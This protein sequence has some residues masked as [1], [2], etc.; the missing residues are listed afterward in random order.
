MSCSKIFSEGLPELTYEVIRH[1][2]NDIS[3]LHS[4]IL[5]NR[6]WCR[7]AIPLLW[8]NPFSI[9][10][11]NFNFIEIYLS[12][13]NNN[14]KTKLNDYKINDYSLPSNTLFNYPKFL[15]HLNIYNLISSV[16]RWIKRTKPSR[17]TRNFFQDLVYSELKYNF[18][19]L[20]SMSLFKIIIE[21]EPN[22]HTLEIEFNHTYNKFYDEILKLILQNQNFIH[23]I[24]HLNLHI[25]DDDCTDS[26]KSLIKNLISQLVNS[27]QNLK[28]ILLGYNYFSL[29]QSLLLS[30]VSNCS[31]TLNTIIFYHIDFKDMIN[32]DKVFEQLNVLES[33]H[34]IDCFLHTDIT[35]QIVNLTKPFKLKSL[36]I[37]KLSEIE[38][39]RLFLQKS[40]DYLEN[41]GCG[42]S[43]LLMDQ[44]LLELIIR[45]FKN[46][47]FLS[48]S[49]IVSQKAYLVPCLIKN[50]K[51]NLSYLSISV[52]NTSHSSLY[53][54]AECSS[55]ILQNLGQV[56]PS[57]LEYLYL[58]LCIKEIDYFEV[59]LNNSQ[60]TFIE[61]LLIRSIVSCNIL[62][63][64]KE[65][66]MKK[67]RVKYLAIY[68][69]HDCCNDQELFLL[70]D[71]VKEFS[72]YN[73]K[74]QEYSD[75]QIERYKFI[76][77]IIN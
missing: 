15:N 52:Y 6:L 37:N 18:I 60:G 65:Y 47:N 45:Y 67:K 22:L 66:I 4:C 77:E 42:E 51:H 58:S 28:K 43:I 74:V 29:Y 13:L 36:F 76:K 12:N 55:I 68:Y 62:P 23:K 57:K 16:K 64:I 46:I 33:I 26:E 32:S 7:L 9:P 3:T 40:G 71:E 19:R 11:G 24:R 70:D 38:S 21:Y 53:D 31:N 20:I 41:F 8:E 69:I 14:L 10:T 56:L 17:N 50:I 59:F 44:Q 63:S 49:G 30:K 1:S 72:L 27:N 34:I 73:I 75:L 2:W 35:Q 54:L 61:K 5:V 25:C 48:L 39:L